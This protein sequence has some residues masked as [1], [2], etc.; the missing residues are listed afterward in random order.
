MLREIDF[1]VKKI[2]DSFN[3][4]AFVETWCQMKKRFFYF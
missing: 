4:A 1:E 2:A 3:C